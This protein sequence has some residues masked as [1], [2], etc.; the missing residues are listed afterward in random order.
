MGADQRVFTDVGAVADL[1]E[2]VDFGAVADGGC[3]DS[4]AIDGGVGLDVDA[5]AKLH[6]A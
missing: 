2:V 1:D 6:G 5:V 3:T 4:G